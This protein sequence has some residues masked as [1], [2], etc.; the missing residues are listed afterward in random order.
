M[1]ITERAFGNDLAHKRRAFKRVK[2]DIHLDAGPVANFLANVQ[3]GRLVSLTFPDYNPPA[4]VQP[5]QLPPHCF[6]GSLI[7]GS[8]VTPSD[9]I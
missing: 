5:V 4:D 2:G 3:H 7:R 6:D 9:E 8:L 1:A